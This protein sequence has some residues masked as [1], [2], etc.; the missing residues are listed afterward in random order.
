MTK[1]VQRY[2]VTNKWDRERSR[3][4]LNTLNHDANTG[5]RLYINQNKTRTTPRA[6][7]DSRDG[8]P[9][10]CAAEAPVLWVSALPASIR[11]ARPRVAPKISKD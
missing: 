11:V 7:G 5:I 8:V 3:T 2:W 9:L 6:S 1:D 4:K 10:L